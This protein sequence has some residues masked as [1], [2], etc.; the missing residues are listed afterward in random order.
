MIITP[1]GKM[2]KNYLLLLTTASLMVGCANPMKN[3]FL[4]DILTYPDKIKLSDEQHE[5]IIK[6]SYLSR[7]LMESDNRAEIEKTVIN[8]KTYTQ[9]SLNNAA[10]A[11]T[12]AQM[13]TDLV[14]GKLNSAVGN[15]IGAATFGAGLLFGE[16]FDGSHEYASQAWIP[17]IYNGTSI[18][19]P[20]MA[21]KALNELTTQQVLKVA[22]TMG[23]QAECVIG[24]NTGSKD[25][26]YFLSN[27]DNKPLHADYIYKPENIAIRINFTELVKIKNSDPIHALIGEKIGWTTKGYNS[28]VVSAMGGIVL[29]ETGKPMITKT[30]DGIDT[31]NI[32]RRL[33]ET[34]LGRDILRT[35]HSTPYTYQGNG[36][37]YPKTIF[38]N[39]VPYT[40]VSNSNTLIASYYLSEPYL[41][42]RKAPV[43]TPPEMQTPIAVGDLR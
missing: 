34:H 39:K 23:W 31:I 4:A 1:K 7:A 18:T 17:N 32:W 9:W 38:Y 16:I 14:V 19:T 20:E 6:V 35:Y 33:G 42:D 15:Q 37:H 40:F 36:D 43:I 25:I 10:E 13:T 28:Y 27:K 21:Q 26:Y 8:S 24:C 11:G 29:N 41:L 2:R 3:P 5:Q 12:M 30:K 22:N